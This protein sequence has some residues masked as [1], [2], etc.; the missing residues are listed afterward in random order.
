M[1]FCNCFRPFI[2]LNRYSTPLQFAD[3]KLS[4]LQTESA[5]PAKFKLTWNAKQRRWFKVYHGK[6]YAFGGFGPNPTKQNSYGKALAAW[7]AKRKELD[8]QAAESPPSIGQLKVRQWC[9]GQLE[10]AEW[11]AKNKGNTDAMAEA[12]KL[13]TMLANGSLPSV[14]PSAFMVEVFAQPD[15]MEAVQ[16]GESLAENISAYLDRQRAKGI[17]ARRVDNERIHLRD[18]GGFH[19]GK[20]I[21]SINAIALENYHGHLLAQCEGRATGKKRIAKSYAKDRLETVKA[22]VRW[23]WGREQ[24][25]LPRNLD[26]LTIKVPPLAVK[27]MPIDD[28]KTLLDNATSSVKLYLLLML[29]CGMTQVDIARLRQAEVDFQAGR[30]RRK[31]TK[32]KDCEGVPIVDYPLWA[33]TFRLLKEHR[34][35]DAELALV[36]ANG[37]ALRREADGDDGK[38]DCSCNISSAYWRLAKPLGIASPPKLIRKLSA[39]TLAGHKS[40]ARYAQHFLGHSPRTVADKHYIAPSAK[41]FDLA[42]RWLGKQFGF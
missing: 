4:P 1:R 24:I 10:A 39:S 16:V 40:Y 25:D 11:F 23:L 37:V 21:K 32:T 19:G 38:F 7:E 33:E 5:M 13:R 41:Q 42:V 18:F 8:A 2:G 6:Q 9:E 12:A 15:L 34:S 27:T 30:I 17:V 29:N 31:R 36:N 14:L 22:F 28:L 20:S 26:G 3:L 35:A